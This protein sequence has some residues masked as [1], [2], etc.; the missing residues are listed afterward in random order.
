[1]AGEEHP[2]VP[3]QSNNVLYTYK[4]VEEDE[5]GRNPGRNVAI[6]IDVQRPASPQGE[7]NDSNIASHSVARG[8]ISS[9]RNQA[10]V[11]PIQKR[12]FLVQIQFQIAIGAGVLWLSNESE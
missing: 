9:F 12:S 6:A 5:E 8:V 1:M 10:P 11:I 4:N 7:M 3:G 2:S